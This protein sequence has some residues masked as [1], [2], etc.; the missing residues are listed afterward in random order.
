MRTADGDGQRTQGLKGERYIA[1]GADHGGY[2]LK[3]QIMSRVVAKWV[4]VGAFDQASSNYAEFAQKVAQAVQNHEV[5]YGIVIC[6]SGIGVTIAANRYKHVYAALC[7]NELMAKSARLHNNA[8]LLCLA[9]DYTT[10]DQAIEMIEVFLT[11][12]F[13][14]GSRHEQRVNSIDLVDC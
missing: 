4:D 9:A 6:R 7:L 14:T 5:D 3:Q 12:A 10:A 8:N 1:I 13:A 11:T 2:H